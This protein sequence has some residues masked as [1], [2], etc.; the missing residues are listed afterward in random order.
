MFETEKKSLNP[1]GGFRLKS[2]SRR[3]KNESEF[4]SPGYP[5][6]FSVIKHAGFWRLQAVESWEWWALV[7]GAWH[8]LPLLSLCVWLFHTD[9]RVWSVIHFVVM[10]LGTGK[11]KGVANLYMKPCEKV[12]IVFFKSIQAQISLTLPFTTMDLLDISPCSLL[13]RAC[14]NY[15]Y[16][17]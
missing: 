9:H 2:L 4:A 15:T 6:F 3:Y 5:F 8:P 10:N 13:W 1:I 17:L 12:T 7:R 11:G 16:R 14:G